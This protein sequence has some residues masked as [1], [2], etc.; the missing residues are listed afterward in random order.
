LDINLKDRLP[1]GDIINPKSF[2]TLLF[3]LFGVDFL[4]VVLEFLDIFGLKTNGSSGSSFITTKEI[5]ILKSGL[6]F[7]Y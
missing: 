3:L 7:K 1:S 6:D 4:G 2:S 5:G